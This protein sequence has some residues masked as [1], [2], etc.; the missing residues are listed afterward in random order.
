MFLRWSGRPGLVRSGRP[1][2]K[3]VRQF[4]AVLLLLPVVIRNA[5]A[6]SSASGQSRISERLKS[7]G[8]NSHGIG[9]PTRVPGTCVGIG[10]WTKNDYQCIIIT[11][12]RPCLRGVS[13]P[14][15][16]NSFNLLVLPGYP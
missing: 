1:G 16:S 11:T 10:D 5:T 6:S 13:Q 7:P 15:N 14:P 2:L 4:R 12:A 8:S 3:K 9:I